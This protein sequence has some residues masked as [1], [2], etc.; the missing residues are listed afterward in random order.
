MQKKVIFFLSAVPPWHL[1]PL[2][3]SGHISPAVLFYSSPVPASSPPP[4][5]PFI[6]D[7]N[8]FVGGNYLPLIIPTRP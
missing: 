1:R 6:G 4:P 5:P 2:L 3:S 7:R 8:L